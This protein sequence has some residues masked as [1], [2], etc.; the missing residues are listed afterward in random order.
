MFEFLRSRN[1][2]DSDLI[3]KRIACDDEEREYFFFLKNSQLF[4]ASGGLL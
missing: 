4:D 2:E 1:I 3:I